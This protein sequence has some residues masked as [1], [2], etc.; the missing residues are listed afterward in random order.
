M[1]TEAP[2]PDEVTGPWW[3]A[4]R[5]RVLLVQSCGACGHAQHPPRA[6]CVGCGSGRDLGWTEASGA[7]EVDACTVVERAMPGFDPPYVV[8]RVRLAEG[9]LLLSNV[10]AADPYRVGVGVPLRLDWRP[11]PDGRALPVFIP[12]EE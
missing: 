1:S 8:A 3:D 5:R 4:T 10:G 9:V 12:S 7:A 11:L 2:E 6:L